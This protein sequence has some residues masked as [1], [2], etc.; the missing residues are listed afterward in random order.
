MGG[1][2]SQGQGTNTI[3]WKRIENLTVN[4]TALTA[5]T[6]APSYPTRTPQQP[7]TTNLT[8]TLLKYG[9]FIILNEEIDLYQYDSHMAG[10]T[11]VLG[12]QAGRTVNQLQRNEEEDNSTAI[13]SN[14]A[15]SAAAIVTKL[16]EADVRRAV[17]VLNRNDAM[18][19]NAAAG[20]SS[21]FNTTPIRDTYWGICHVDVEED[22]RQMTGFVDVA[23]YMGTTQI[24]RGEF[25][26]T[27]NGVRW[28]ST[29][30]ASIDAEA[31]G[32]NVTPGLRSSGNNKT[33]VYN[34]LIF[35]QKSYASV[36][37]DT[38]FFQETYMAGD[39]VPGIQTI[40]HARGTAGAADPLNEVS[41]IG[42]KT[43]HVGKVINNNWSRC[44]RSGASAL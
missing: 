31:G 10:I 14:S 34:T 7:T 36:S 22:V 12:I 30:E 42:W 23:S 38:P 44:I 43:F 15:A 17:N 8:A 21:N 9:Q 39:Q 26:H 37:L 1:E 27:R 2:V 35:G 25:G 20:G 4:L 32:N 18:K 11:E 5:L 3:S 28:I 40:G 16:L 29:S 13:L 24:A 19:F 6:G 33:D 41:T